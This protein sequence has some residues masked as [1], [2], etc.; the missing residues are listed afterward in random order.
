MKK[1]QQL[2]A[3][4]AGILLA[5]AAFFPALAADNPTKT[6]KAKDADSDKKAVHNVV[7]GLDQLGQ[8]DRRRDPHQDGPDTLCIKEA[9]CRGCSHDMAVLLTGSG[10]SNLPQRGGRDLRGRL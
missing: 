1:Q 10:S 4:T 8:H 5:A 3:C 7:K 9:V 2:A 6:A